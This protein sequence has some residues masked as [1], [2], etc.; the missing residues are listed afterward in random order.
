[1]IGDIALVGEHLQFSRSDSG[2]RKEIGCVDGLSREN[3]VGLARLQSTCS[4]ESWVRP[5]LPLVV[6]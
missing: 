1:L 6:L 5:E 2:R 4:V 3:V